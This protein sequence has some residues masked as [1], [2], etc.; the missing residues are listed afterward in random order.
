MLEEV[1]HDSPEDPN[2][3]IVNMVEQFKTQQQL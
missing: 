3:V 2:E 1:F